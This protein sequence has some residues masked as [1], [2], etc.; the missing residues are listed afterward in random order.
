M[1]G[2]CLKRG[3]SGPLLLIL[4]TI[5]V[6]VPH[7]GC[8]RETATRCSYDGVEINPRYEVQF[9]MKDGTLLRFCSMAC[10][11]QAFVQAKDNIETVLVTDEVTG[12]K[13]RAEE[14]YFIES[15]VVTVPHVNNR[16]HVFASEPEAVR[17]RDQFSGVHLPNPFVLFDPW[18]EEMLG[19]KKL[20]IKIDPQTGLTRIIK[21]DPYIM[22]LQHFDPN[23]FDREGAKKAAGALLALLGNYLKVSVDELTLSGMEQIGGSWY[24]SFWQTYGPVI[25]FESSIGFSISPEGRISSVGALLHQAHKGLNLPT[26]AKLGLKEAEAIARAYLM[27]KEPWDYKLVAYQLIIYPRKGQQGAVDYYLAYILNFYYPEA[28]R[29]T[30][31]WA[32]WICFVDAVSGDIIDLQHLIAIASCCMPVDDET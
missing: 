1:K 13:L 15:S 8:Q 5:F 25:I 19:D 29:V 30:R 3:I 18:R 28:Y 21:G 9:A 32:G 31:S 11:L 27:K 17:H 10:A 23:H 14:A 7:G 6:M 16:I 26:R 2:I 4:L 22:S 24:V 12:R 20:R